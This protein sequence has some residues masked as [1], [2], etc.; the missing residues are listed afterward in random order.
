MNEQVAEHFEDHKEQ[1]LKNTLRHDPT[2]TQPIMSPQP[3]CPPHVPLSV[4]EKSVKFFEILFPAL[5]ALS[6]VG[7]SITFS[8]IFIQD[9]E[10]PANVSSQPRFSRNDVRNLLAMSWLLWTFTLG[11]SIFA[12]CAVSFH[13]DTIKQ[14]FKERHVGWRWWGTVSSGGLQALGILAFI[15]MSLVVVA[16]VE[17]VGWT[18]VGFWSVFGVVALGMVFE[19]SPACDPVKIWNQKRTWKKEKL[20]RKESARVRFDDHEMGESH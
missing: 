14:G 7:S 2:S 13:R 4:G 12:A 18:A 11:L 6:S 19:Q 8:L 20:Q 10:D 3:S 16:Y 5:I 15:F 17:F 1:T 9:V